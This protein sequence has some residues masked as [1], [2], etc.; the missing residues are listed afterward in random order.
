MVA[1]DN[2]ASLPFGPIRPVANLRRF[3]QPRSL[4]S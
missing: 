2:V 3:R 1:V 4:R